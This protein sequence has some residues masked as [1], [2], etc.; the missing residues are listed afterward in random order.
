MSLEIIAIVISI[1]TPIFI[2]LGRNT[3][4]EWIKSSFTKEIEQFKHELDIKKEVLKQDLTKDAQRVA[5]LSSSK[6]SLYPEFYEKL[7]VTE[8]SVGLL[9]GLQQV[10]NYSKFPIEELLNV[11]NNLSAVD[12]MKREV[13]EAIK[14]DKDEGIKALQSLIREIE[15][16]TAKKK[17]QD[18]KNFLILKTLYFSK[19]VYDKSF[20]VIKMFNSLIIDIQYQQQNRIPYEHISGQAKAIE[21]AIDV[22]EAEMRREMF[23]E[24]V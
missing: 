8:G 3:I 22:L 19:P 9:H 18:A 20:E 23:G 24:Q 2:F 6:Q 5:Y 16:S 4:L 14:R 17:C 15:I 1:L 10:P 21:Q 11:V 7:R 12:G 13:H